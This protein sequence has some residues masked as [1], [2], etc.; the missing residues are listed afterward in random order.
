MEENG[1]I[2][3]DVREDYDQHVSNLVQRSD[4][5]SFLSQ[6]IPAVFLHTG[7]HPDYHM[8]TDTIEKINFPKF[9][10]ITKLGFRVVWRL[11][12]QQA[13]PQPPHTKTGTN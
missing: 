11:A 4:H 5:W 3:L 8:P 9:A 13:P 1:A 10:K 2:G 12:T 6:G 7:L